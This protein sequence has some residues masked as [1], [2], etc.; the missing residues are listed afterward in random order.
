MEDS[1]LLNKSIDMCDVVEY[2]GGMHHEPGIVSAKLMKMN[3]DA[4][5]ATQNKQEERNEIIGEVKMYNLSG[6]CQ[7]EF[8]KA[9]ANV[10]GMGI[11]LCPKTP[12]I[13]SFEQ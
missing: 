6:K 5:K 2:Q 13:H 3:A 12:V 8:K 11:N 10:Y 7:G 1:K 9:P 4:D